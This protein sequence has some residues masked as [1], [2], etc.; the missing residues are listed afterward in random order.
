MA[1]KFTAEQRLSDV[2]PGRINGASRNGLRTT[3][4]ARNLGQIPEE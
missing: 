4:G 2:R 1:A 3:C